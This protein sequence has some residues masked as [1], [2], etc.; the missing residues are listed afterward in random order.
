MVRC[1]RPGFATFLTTTFAAR[2]AGSIATAMLMLATISDLRAQD[3][4]MVVRIEPLVG[5][6]LE[7]NAIAM[8]SEGRWTFADQEP[9]AWSEVRRIEIERPQSTAT[10]AA[11]DGTFAITLVGGGQ[12]QVTQIQLLDEAF[13]LQT[14]FGEVIVPIEFVVGGIHRAV[15]P[16]DLTLEKPGLDTDRVVVLVE[17][18]GQAV[19]GLVETVDSEGIEFSFESS[20]RKLTWDRVLSFS[21]AS[22]GL[23]PAETGVRV[24][25]VDGD[26]WFGVPV[27][28]DAERLVLKL[29]QTQEVTITL[30][31]LQRIEAISDR[32]RSLAD[33]EI[34]SEETKGLLLPPRPWRRHQ[35]VQ[36]GVLRPNRREPGSPVEYAQGIGMASGTT[37]V[38]PCEGYD[39]FVSLVAI[40]AS[41]NGYGDC[42]VVVKVDDQERF[43]RRLTGADLPVLVDLPLDGAQTLSLIVEYGEGL[44]LADHVDWCDAR[45]LK[46]QTR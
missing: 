11:A 29:G 8:D 43:R 13:Q 27:S 9:L 21:M 3:A 28:C 18:Q 26:R 42:E 14:R 19:D 22:A 5:N 41:A 35:S 1:L 30:D 17:G 40:D 25:T 44:D 37:L 36:G 38:F 24:T 23:D 39:R 46:T 4:G 45:L 2:W 6:R 31:R 33:L 34:V 7:A 16:A 12:V 15:A 20:T 10:P 32:E